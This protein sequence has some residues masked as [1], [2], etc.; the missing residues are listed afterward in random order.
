MRLK[1]NSER[2]FFRIINALATYVNDTRGVSGY[3]FDPN[4][5]GKE[6]DRNMHAILE[7]LWDDRSIIDQ[8][9]AENPARLNQADL[10]AVADWKYAA[11][12]IFFLVKFESGYAHFMIDGMIYEVMGLSREIS[13]M[14]SEHDLPKSVAMTLLPYDGGI[15]YDTQ[16]AEM[17]VTY[18]PRAA[19]VLNNDYESAKARGN[20]YRSAQALIRNAEH[21]TEANRNRENDRKLDE[22]QREQRRADPDIEMPEGMHRGI[23]ADVSFEQREALQNEIMRSDEEINE[24]YRLVFEE[25]TKQYPK[26]TPQTSFEKAM[27]VATKDQLMILAKSL[28]KPVKSKMRKDEIIDTFLSDPD[29]PGELVDGALTLFNNHDYEL[30]MQLLE[31]DGYLVREIS[32]IGFE[33]LLMHRPPFICHYQ[34][35]SQLITVLPKELV[36]AYRKLDL[37]QLQDA[38][39]RRLYQR[40]IMDC[41]NVA[42]SLYGIVSILE[43]YE[44]YQ[45][46]Y[47]EDGLGLIELIELVMGL[48]SRS[49]DVFGVWVDFGSDSEN[50]SES[51]P[52]HGEFWR[53][54]ALFN[55]IFIQNIELHTFADGHIR[56]SEG[57]KWSLAFGG[58]DFEGF[59]HG[60][61]D[62]EDADEDDEG[63]DEEEYLE[64]FRNHLLD[65]HVD[66]PR[67]LL[68][69]DE[70]DHFSMSGF[71]RQIPE[72]QQL[73]G[74]FDT[75]VPDGLDDILFADDLF[76]L[77][78]TA[79]QF[80]TDMQYY[81]DVLEAT[82]FVFASTQALED[83]MAMLTG[84]MNA[85]PRWSNNGHSP[86]EMLKLGIRPLS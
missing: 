43:Y 7:S 78:L 81:S 53:S 82:G 30:F 35:G 3:P 48:Y 14:I 79:M 70:L 16:I 29:L 15:V 58:F 21:H 49:N 60:D 11:K 12:G 61:F 74:Y 84:A 34:S 13:D 17:Q 69:K 83:F 67:R 72:V 37:Q 40:H 8:F 9:I 20:I 27:H 44:L 42:V 32:E 52:G 28:Q 63:E 38:A 85:I 75:Y 51:C 18:M 54:P 55:S 10:T 6:Y 59:I 73:I 5:P 46:Y 22:Y 4:A 2:R 77:F 68:E 56:R 62:Y 71:C 76:E 33:D 24:L 80:D 1:D 39:T 66:I 41:V 25:H 45:R 31:S 65:R 36:E 64:D 86:N 26:K 23:L 50:N 57:E 19:E 47:P